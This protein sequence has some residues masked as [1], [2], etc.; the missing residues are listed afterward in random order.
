MKTLEELKIMFIDTLEGEQ[1]LDPPRGI[2]FNGIIKNPRG[3]FIVLFTLDNWVNK[4]VWDYCYRDYA[5]YG[6]QDICIVRFEETDNTFKRY[7]G[8]G[9]AMESVG[10]EKCFSSFKGKWSV[11]CS[12]V[13]YFNQNSPAP[14][15]SQP[16][17]SEN[18]INPV[19]T[20]KDL[21]KQIKEMI[22]RRVEK[23]MAYR[24]SDEEVN[25]IT[26]N[27]YHEI[28]IIFTNVTRGECKLKEATSKSSFFYCEPKSEWLK[29]LQS[30]I[31]S[32]IEN[33]NQKYDS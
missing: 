30:D 4:S 32:M 25:N 3:K 2:S 27:L 14:A 29:N 9:L 13:Y 15:I 8:A 12:P 11:T 23:N 20:L 10:K 1:W 6:Y 17:S 24:Y 31:A 26:E 16:Q 28:D 33:F 18:K 22:S 21:Q 5:A 19:P 7:F